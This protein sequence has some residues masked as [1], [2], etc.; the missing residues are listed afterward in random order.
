MI[1]MQTRVHSKTILNE[2]FISYSSKLA[3]KF[4]NVLYICTT[5]TLYSIRD[6]KSPKC[7]SKLKSEFLNVFG[8]SDKCMHVLLFITSN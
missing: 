4:L 7:V 5:R 1:D 6:L 8:A 2:C 3:R